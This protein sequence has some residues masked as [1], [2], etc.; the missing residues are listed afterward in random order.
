MTISQRNSSTQYNDYQNGGQP[1]PFTTLEKIKS[2][3]RTNFSFNHYF[4]DELVGLYYSSLGSQNIE[5]S[6]KFQTT[7][8][9]SP[10]ILQTSSIQFPNEFQGKQ[11]WVLKLCETN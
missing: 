8:R 10:D 6:A 2:F 3:F 9:L 5:L 4:G 7:E 11:K 1:K